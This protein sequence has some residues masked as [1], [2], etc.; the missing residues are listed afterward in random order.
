MTN[1]EKDRLL[2]L[3]DFFHTRKET[4]YKLRRD[5]NP[6]TREFHRLAGREAAWEDAERVLRDVT[7]GY[8]IDKEGLLPPK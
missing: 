1:E 4:C 7:N 6:R 3:A 2:A 5:L 8:I